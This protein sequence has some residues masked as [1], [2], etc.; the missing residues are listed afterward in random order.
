MDPETK[1]EAQQVA[2]DMGV[3]LSTVVNAQLRRFIRERR[4]ELQAPLVPNAKTRKLLDEA[5]REFAA[6]KKHKVHADLDEMFRA[7]QS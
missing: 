3:P 4:V 1:R 5:E 7:L 6:K 2:K